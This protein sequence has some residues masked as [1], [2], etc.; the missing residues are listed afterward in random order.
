MDA[1]PF[2][3]SGAPVGPIVGGALPGLWHASAFS[4]SGVFCTALGGFVGI[5][6]TYKVTR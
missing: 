5:W 4:W 6:V 3:L 2:I 1:K